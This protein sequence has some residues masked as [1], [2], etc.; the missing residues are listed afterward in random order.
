MLD[1]TVT[2]N[3]VDFSPYI[4]SDSY[5][6][7]KIPVYSEE[8]VTMDGVTH[9][10]NLRNKSEVSF[11]FNPQNAANTATLCT[12]LLSLPCEVYF[13]SLQTQSYEVASMV[14]DGQSAS[15][16]SRCLYRGEKWTRVESILLTEL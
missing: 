5:S 16:L 9:V 11:A 12:A 1:Y 14:L 2:V 13:F 10:A 15:Y 8:V 7:G 4:E 3:G 6:T